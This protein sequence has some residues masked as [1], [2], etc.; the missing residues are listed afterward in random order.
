LD[1]PALTSRLYNSQTMS[2]IARHLYQLQDLELAIDANE[3]AQT[4]VQN[5]LKDNQAVLKIHS[6]LTE[7]EKKLDELAKLQKTTEWEIDDLSGK[8]KT[9]EKKLYDGKIHNPKELQSLQIEQTDFNKMRSA[10]E[11]KELVMMDQAD[12]LRNSISAVKTEVA[13]AE[14]QWQE[15]QKKLSADLE[16]LKNDRAA[17]EIQKQSA[18]SQIDAQSLAAYLDVKKRRGVAVAKIEQGICKGCRITLPNSVLQQAKGGGLV[19]CSSCGR[20]LFLP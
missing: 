1:L 19:K 13:A 6:R 5:Q 2:T 3:Q 4:R 12:T 7:E 8:I 15:Q 9:I 16:K 11:D 17:L 20:I 18:L 14:A 10:L